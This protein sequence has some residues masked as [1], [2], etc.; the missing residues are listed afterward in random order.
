M[1]DPSPPATLVGTTATRT[2]TVERAQTTHVFGEQERPSGRPAAVDGPPDE[3]VRVL[4][5]APLLSRVEF[6]GRD[7][8]RGRIP[9][10]TGVVGKRASVTHL[11]AAAVGTRV[12]VRTEVVAV[13]GAEITYE[14]RV[15][16]VEDGRSVAEVEVVFQLVDRNQFRQR[17]GVDET[18]AAD[19]E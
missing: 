9:R 11:G 8:I 4:G 2:F 13:D 14:G 18:G 1:D 17:V 7:S 12:R 16:T 3:G 19:E 5:T 15:E 10:G 6:A